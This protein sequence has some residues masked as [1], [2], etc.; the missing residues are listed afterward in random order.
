MRDSFVTMKRSPAAT[1]DSSTMMSSAAMSVKPCE[2]FFPC[3][4]CFGL[5][6]LK[7][8]L[9]ISIAKCHVARADGSRQEQV[10]RFVSVVEHALAHDHNVDLLHQVR[11]IPNSDGVGLVRV[12]HRVVRVVKV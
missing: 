9:L 5:L 8:R 12:Q 7:K 1:P 4:I 10:L 6:P 2:L 11:G 3:P